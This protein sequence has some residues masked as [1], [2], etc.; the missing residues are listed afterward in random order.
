[1]S[2]TVA[3]A[4]IAD[5]VMQVRTRIAAAAR[6]AGRAASEITVI[7]VTKTVTASSI[8]EAVIAGIRDLGENKVQ[9][10]ARYQP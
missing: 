5:Q 4:G 1:M 6:R 3:Q 2:E 7:A 9:E 10:A 8:R